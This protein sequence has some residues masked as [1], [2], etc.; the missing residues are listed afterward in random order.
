[1]TNY[2]IARRFTRI[3][4]ILEIQGENPFKIKAYRR[5]AETIEELTEPLSEIDARGALDDIPGFGSAIV[6]KTHDFLTVGTTKLYEQIKDAV[7]AGVVRMAAVP[8]I[9]PKTAKSLWDALGVDDI[10]PLEE[11]ARAGKVQ[12]V[13]GFGAAKEKNLIE[14][15][16]RNRRL[17]E[18]LPAY[19]ALPYAERLVR[20]LSVLPE[21]VQAAVAGSLRRGRD[22]VGDIDLVAATTDATATAENFAHLSGVT[23]ILASGPAEVVGFADLGVRVDLR[24][25]K[26]SEFGALLHHFSSGREHNRQLRALAEAQGLKIN[27]YGLFDAATD[28]E[29]SLSPADD[30]EA[31]YRALGL[32]RY[33]PNYAKAETRFGWLRAAHCRN[34]L[35]KPIFTDNCTVTRPTPMAPPPSGRWRTPPSRAATNTSPSPTTPARS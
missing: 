31:I 3:G 22:T 29:K 34:S 35:P 14:A 4:D 13:P 15:I 17:T 6:A 1:M 28:V 30:E 20:E 32:P 2:E 8:G 24:L 10:A 16:E 5:A 33:R 12:K 19:V 26:P 7:P 18:R 21:V 25:G 9:G 11:A 23:E 27:E